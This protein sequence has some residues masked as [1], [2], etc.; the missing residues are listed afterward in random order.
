[1]N[2]RKRVAMLKH[3][4]RR[5]KLEAKNRA[6]AGSVGAI[7]KVS[8]MRSVAKEEINL[9]GQKGRAGGSVVSRE[10]A[11]STRGD[12]AQGQRATRKSASNSRAATASSGKAT[13]KKVLK[14]DLPSKKAKQPKEPKSLAHKPKART[15]K[16]V[17]S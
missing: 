6:L 5:I 3:R 16:S 4:K 13:T 8:K 17:N 1:M 14:K 7:K 11:E 15:R 10:D 9:L 2:K 12:A